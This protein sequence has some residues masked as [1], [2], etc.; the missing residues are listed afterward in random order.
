M[1]DEEDEQEEEE[2]EEE[3]IETCSRSKGDDNIREEEDECYPS[4]VAVDDDDDDNEKGETGSPN[5]SPQK[6]ISSSNIL[7]HLE[8][9]QELEKKWSTADDEYMKQVTS[10]GSY[11]EF[12]GVYEASFLKCRSYFLFYAVAFCCTLFLLSKIDVPPGNIFE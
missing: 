3:S 12:F 11:A 8:L 1:D 4:N 9:F 7:S 10:P 6:D 2:E 5:L